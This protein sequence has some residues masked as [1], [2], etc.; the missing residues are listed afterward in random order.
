MVRNYN[1]L[2]VSPGQVRSGQQKQST[3][4]QRHAYSQN[5]ERVKIEGKLNELIDDSRVHQLVR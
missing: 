3:C 2:Y 4:F 5:D 1:L